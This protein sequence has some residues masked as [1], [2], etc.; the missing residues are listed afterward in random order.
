MTRS[1]SSVRRR[2][3]A[4]LCVLF[5][6][7]ILLPAADWC[8]AVDPTPALDENRD[9]APAPVRPEDWVSFSKLVKGLDAYWSD[10]FGFRRW[11]I[12]M[13]AYTNYEFGNSSSDLVVIGS[14]NWLF[15][16][17]EDSNPNHRGTHPFSNAELE[18]WR[19][20]LE[21]RQAW[22][23]SKGAKFLFVIA[24]DKQSIYP[25]ALPD[26]LRPIAPTPADQLVAYMAQR[27]TVPVLDLRPVLIAAKDGPPVYHRT[28]THWNDRGAL[29]GYEAVMARLKEW[30]PSLTPRDQAQFS[31]V[32]AG[33][34]SGDMAVMMGLKEFLAEPLVEYR[35]TA[36]TSHLLDDPNRPPASVRYSAMSGPP[37]RPRA[38]FFHDSFFLAPES[39]GDPSKPA[40]TDRFIP[41]H[42]AFQMTA[43]LGEQFS[44]SAFTWQHI[45]DP[46]LVVR[47]HPDVV[48]EEVVERAI[49]GGPHG[50][51][52]R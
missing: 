38:V 1:A 46:D 14:H 30:Y 15:Y 52:P 44:R 26:T 23:A 20:E 8:F 25:E 9:L 29:L 18:A 4:L 50:S 6:V 47:E 17:G 48:V 5:A 41:K 42:S 33:W 37:G 27:S 49:R 16:A 24:P 43:L 36:T 31:P 12:R 19:T 51:A 32:K 7:A 2:A 11:L 3:D 10:H 39:R 34:W 22:L 40:R 35:T 13:N 28:D 21:A 45:F